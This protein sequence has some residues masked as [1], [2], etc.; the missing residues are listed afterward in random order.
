TQYPGLARPAPLAPT[1]V[2]LSETP[3][4]FRHR[5]PTLGEHTD[6]I[7]KELGYSGE[8]IAG[9]RARKVV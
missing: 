2:D 1:P 5:A 6:E 9:L 4:S 8:E 3:G 7:L